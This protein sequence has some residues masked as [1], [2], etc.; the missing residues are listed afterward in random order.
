MAIDKVKYWKELSDYDM[1]TAEVMY[2][3][4]RWLYVGFMC[5][6]VIEKTIKAKWSRIKPDKK[7]FNHNHQKL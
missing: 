2:R 5:H 1:E 3:G 6:Q 4:S 7:P